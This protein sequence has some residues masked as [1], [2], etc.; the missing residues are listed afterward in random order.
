M[1]IKDI[2]KFMEWCSQGRETYPLLR[3]MFLKQKENVET[4]IERM[5]RVL[6]MLKYKCRYYEQAIKDGSEE[7]L[8]SM[9]PE[10][11]P[12]EIRIAYENT[13]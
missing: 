12:E 8:S 9:T 1:E 6:D 11:M 5:N 7:R 2:K 3:K 13:H 10:E 4:E